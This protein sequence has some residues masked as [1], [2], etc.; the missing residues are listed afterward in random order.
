MFQ[1][2]E[3]DLARQEIPL[4][5]GA[6]LAAAFILEAYGDSAEEELLARENNCGI[7]PARLGLYRVGAV[8]LTGNEQELLR[9]AQYPEV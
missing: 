4:S 2:Y 6:E 9:K 1:P 8:A 5:E 3:I 7:D